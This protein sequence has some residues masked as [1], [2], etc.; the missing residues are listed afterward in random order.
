ME[1]ADNFGRCAAVEWSLETTDGPADRAG[2]VGS[3]GDDDSGGERGCVQ[4]VL[5]P[6]DKVRVEGAG[7]GRIGISTVELLQEAARE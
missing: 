4:T 7:S 3:S 6:D 1:L 5:G 2:Q